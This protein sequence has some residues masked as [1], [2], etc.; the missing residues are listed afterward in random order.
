MTDWA[1]LTATLDKALTVDSSAASRVLE[2]E[3]SDPQTRA[4]ARRLMGRLR[5]GAGFMQTSAPLGLDLP[6]PIPE[7]TRIHVWQI[8]ALIGRGGMGEVYRAKRCDG[9]YE[10]T[11]AIKLMF[12]S[13]ASRA[14]RFS[15]ERRRLAQ[16]DHPGIA[17]ILDGG[18]AADGRSYLVMDYVDGEPID[19][20]IRRAKPH[21]SAKL[22]LFSQV[23]SAVSHA[24]A[25][26]ILHRDIKAQNVL[27][28]QSGR[29]RL[30]DFGISS[31][32]EE[33]DLLGEAL[34]LATAAP[35]QLQGGLITV[36]TD[37]FALGVLLHHMLVGR[38]PERRPDAGM[39]I[40]TR[41]INQFDMRAILTR[42][43]AKEPIERYA[44]VEA[45][46]N[47]V[48]AFLAHRPVAARQGGALYRTQRLI[49]RFPLATVLAGAAVAAL[50]G[51]LTFSLRFA[52]EA[53][54]EAKRAKSALTKA[55]WQFQRAEAGLGAQRAYSDI[56]QRAFGGQ[57]DVARLSDLMLERWNEAFAART[58]DPEAAAAV[59]YAVGRNFYFRG[60]NKRALTVFDAWLTTPFGSPPL[61]E[62][63]EEVYALML[64]DA[65]RT[66]EAEPRLR[67]L[68][69]RFSVGY[70]ES[71]PDLLNYAFKLARIT[72][73]P[74]DLNRAESLIIDLLGDGSGPP[75]EAILHYNQLGF[76]R[77]AK[78][79]RQG[80]YEAFRQC[81]AVFD[82]N[83][84][85]ASSGR[86]IARFNLA[87]QELSF[88]RDLARAEALAQSIL[89]EDVPLKGES[90]QKGRALMLLALVA[91]EHK[92]FAT[93]RANMAE[94]NVLFLR[95]SGVGAPPHVTGLAISAVIE[96]DAGAQEAAQSQLTELAALVAEVPPTDDRQQ[97]YSM[98]RVMADAAAGADKAQLA[99][100]LADPL[101][102]RGIRN[103]TLLYYFHRRLT[104][105]ELASALPLLSAAPTSP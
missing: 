65:G 44:S 3:V 62:L 77:T 30:I 5:L 43:L 49:K 53:R 86:D 90:I 52:E 23:C 27:V 11:V 74:E 55:E 39:T 45:L 36:Q 71:K 50:V 94:A 81:L 64:T 20:H 103:N 97:L 67:A 63:G 80:A 32:I 72:R 26:L 10:Q 40:S 75:F 2:D 21:L 13:S 4:L 37:V 9:L 93:A 87:S 7:G 48:E 12:G 18:E 95:Y 82:A 78:D 47:D 66:A 24:H 17:R 99:D 68:V 54:Q 8:E 59:S 79:D 92:D 22:G 1:K 89:A 76:L 14:E 51:G 42:A 96:A 46:R 73:A 15:N 38:M 6:E 28:D 69:E 105:A 91:S 100:R 101:L 85:L 61:V 35:E 84:D 33:D 29:A 83:P 19:Q 57:E 25:R 16:M 60:D 34:T 88:T 41:A 56:L 104:E 102:H 58:E 31:I 98:A 70:E